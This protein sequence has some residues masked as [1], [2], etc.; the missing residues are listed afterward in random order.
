MFST[1]LH[2]YYIVLMSG[3]A[4]ETH[5]IHYPFGLDLSFLSYPNTVEV[6]LSDKNVLRNNIN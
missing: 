2:L 5:V 4:A 3:Q 6:Y 1:I